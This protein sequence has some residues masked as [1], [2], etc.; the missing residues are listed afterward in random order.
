[1]VTH[2]PAACFLDLSRGDPDRM[3]STGI[4]LTGSV[5]QYRLEGALAAARFKSLDIVA[6]G[7]HS[8]H[9]FQIPV[10]DTAQWIPSHYGYRLHAERGTQTVDIERGQ[11][12]VEPDFSSLPEG[13]DGRSNK[14]RALNAINAVLEKRATQDQ[15]RDHIN[16]RE[17]WRTSIPE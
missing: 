17:L 5:S 16:N 8:V 10:D 4:M 1:M 6:H 7:E 9:R 13:Y 11:L 3:F 2:A 15:S 14:Q 12:R